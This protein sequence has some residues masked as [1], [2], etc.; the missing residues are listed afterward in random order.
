MLLDV[1]NELYYSVLTKWSSGLT[2]LRYRSKIRTAMVKISIPARVANMLDKF[3]CTPIII[4]LNLNHV[5]PRR[6]FA[7]LPDPVPVPD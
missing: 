7:P 4:K 5:Q 1:S 2:S 3:C 6:H